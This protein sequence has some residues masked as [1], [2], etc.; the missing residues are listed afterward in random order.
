MRQLVDEESLIV[1][2]RANAALRDSAFRRG[3]VGV[4]GSAPQTLN[5]QM[6]TPL[7]QIVGAA[8]R[9]SMLSKKRTRRGV[10]RRVL[11]GPAPRAVWEGGPRHRSSR[12]LLHGFAVQPEVE[13][14]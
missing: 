7:Y 1:F 2:W 14:I 3:P 5:R 12:L 10:F 11:I 6:A 9:T 8:A 13:T 4:E